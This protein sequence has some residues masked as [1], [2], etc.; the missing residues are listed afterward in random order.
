[1]D[2]QSLAKAFREKPLSFIFTVAVFAA[3]IIGPVYLVY[4]ILTSNHRDREDFQMGVRC[5]NWV[6]ESQIEKYIDG[7]EVRDM[8]ARYFASRSPEDAKMDNAV[9]QQKIEAARERNSTA[10]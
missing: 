8:C 1:M 2:R 10:K 5:T 9:W 7:S 3:F 6:H 4:Y